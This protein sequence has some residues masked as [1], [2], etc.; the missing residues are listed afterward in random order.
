MQFIVLLHFKKTIGRWIK[1][2]FFKFYLFFS[3]FWLHVECTVFAYT[4]RVGDMC[5]RQ[6]H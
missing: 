5:V 3:E 2:F 4:G 6:S 1:C